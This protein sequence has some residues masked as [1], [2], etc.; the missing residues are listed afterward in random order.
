[1]KKKAHFISILMLCALSLVLGLSRATA[2]NGV[3]RTVHFTTRD[4]LASNVVNTVVQDRKGYIWLGTNQG[5]T[6]YDGYEFVNFYV[7]HDG[8]RQMEN[9]MRIVED[10]V[11]HKLLMINS[12]YHALYF[13]LRTMRFIEDTLAVPL[14]DERELYFRQRAGLD[15]GVNPKNMTARRTCIRYAPL[16]DGRELYTTTDNGIFVYD[17]QRKD[18]QHYS[19][20]DVSPLIRS[21][22]VNDVLRDRTGGIW[23]ATT[24]GGVCLLRC[25]RQFLRH[26]LLE[27]QPKS[28]QMNNVRSF[29][30]LTDTE[31]A[32]SDMEGNVYRHDLQS[33]HTEL[34]L[35]R[36][37]R[38][39]A[40]ATDAKGRLWVG[41]RGGGVW[42]GDR[43]LN[44]KDGLQ[45]GIIFGILHGDNHTAW[46]STL[47]GGLV[48]AREQE[49]GSFTFTYHIRGER[50]HQA[51][52]DDQGRLWVATE[53]GLFRQD[54]KD[55]TPIYDKG[56]VECLALNRNGEM[57]AGTIG[58][59]LMRIG[60]HDE[61]TYITTENGLANNSVKAIVVDHEG[62]IV[63]A[64]DEGNSVI[65]HR[66]GNIQNL[67]VQAGAMAD[68][69]NENAAML[70]RDGQVL[71]GSLSG[72][73]KLDIHQVLKEK[74]PVEMPAPVI[75]ALMVNDTPVY[76]GEYRDIHLAHNQNNLRLDFS[77][78]A[79]RVQPSVIYSYWLSGVDRDWRSSTNHPQAL[80]SNLS[81]GHY[82]FHVRT[83]MAGGSWS[84]ATVC[85]I[86]IAQPW[87]WTWWMRAVYVVLLI[88]IVW[89]ELHQYRQRL[90]LRRQLDQ[91]LAALYATEEKSIE[92]TDSGA[93]IINENEE[94][95]AQGD[96][97]GTLFLDKLDHVILA[98][99]MQTDFDMSALA[100]EMCMSHKTLYRRVKTLTG[101]TANEYVRKH[102]LAKA[103]Q[104]LREGN[105][106]S[107]VAFQCG[108]NSPSYFTRCFKAEYGVTPSSHYV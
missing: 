41:T 31:V 17:P 68:V 43:H 106:V 46:L 29:S 47:D 104:L 7:E 69:Y 62:N 98:N 52:F 49:D 25:D 27:E 77:T 65:S 102:R 81:P 103:L 14:E 42:A 108:F 44:E 20:N 97:E 60:I 85:D 101:M 59:G 8:A 36:P 10:T 73:V 86:Y 107:E 89:L 23:L 13:D 61:I 76:Q 92:P 28:P 38:V 79:Y 18:L 51:A 19:A 99:L 35:Q 72:W 88:L 24:F 93:K 26:Q 2:Q 90:S 75:T 96:L 82:R 80:Y 37:Q 21:D 58:M 39:Y 3:L 105:N 12:D 33:G 22:F 34:F 5:L 91:R 71:L 32:I 11:Q 63:A 9:V 30:Q 84:E 78:F 40:T 66:D 53:T 100:R 16:D 1:M 55:F 4:G 83:A 56:R 15:I 54:G 6:R 50:V 57:L 64:T 45:A 94:L 67:Y 48:E 70:T 74:H 87:W 95:H